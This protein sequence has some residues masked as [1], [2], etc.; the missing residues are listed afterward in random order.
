[1]VGENE[2]EDDEKKNGRMAPTKSDANDDECGGKRWT[3]PQNHE[4]ND[5]E[6]RSAEQIL[7]KRIGCEMVGPL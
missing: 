1:M 4:A 5:V 7:K 2:K 6:R 3:S